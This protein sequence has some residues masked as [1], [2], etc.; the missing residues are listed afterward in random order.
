VIAKEIN[1]KIFEKINKTLRSRVIISTIT[2]LRLCGHNT[3]PR[4]ENTMNERQEAEWLYAKG[5]ELAILI[6]GTQGI[7]IPEVNKTDVITKNYNELAIKIARYIVVK[8]TELI[9]KN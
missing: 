1:L 5:L 4:R 6:K 2:K 3:K 9:R 8:A 7:T